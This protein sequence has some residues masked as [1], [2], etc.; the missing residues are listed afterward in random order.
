MPDLRSQENAPFHERGVWCDFQKRPPAQSR[1]VGVAGKFKKPKQDQGA[2]DFKRAINLAATNI[3]YTGSAY[4]RPPGS[5]KGPA[6][7]LDQS[8]E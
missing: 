7:T 8:C 6:A 5:K 4:H 3:T 2:R 1:R